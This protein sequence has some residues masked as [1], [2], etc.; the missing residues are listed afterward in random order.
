MQKVACLLCF[1]IFESCD[2]VELKMN[3]ITELLQVTEKEVLRLIRNNGMPAHKINK[4]YLFSRQ[5]IKNWILQSGVDI[6][7]RM[8]ESERH[9][10]VA[11]LVRKGSVL[12]GI[13][14]DTPAGILAVAVAAMKLPDELNREDV[15]FFLLQREEMIPTSV[16]RGIAIPHPRKPIVADMDNESIT[17]VLLAEPVDYSALDKKLVHTLFIVLSANSNRH[18]EILSR[19][20]YL[21]QQPDFVTLLENAVPADDLV[22]YIERVEAGIKAGGK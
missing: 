7:T 5:E 4:R 10:S 20:T 21:C 12:G 13:T 9:V 22:A 6:N 14:G 11:E 8:L 1:L 2:V 17:V 18:L 15:L 19:L 16:G 3:D